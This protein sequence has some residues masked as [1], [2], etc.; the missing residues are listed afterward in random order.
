MPAGLRNSYPITT[1]SRGFSENSLGGAEGVLLKSGQLQD[2]AFLLLQ[3]IGQRTLCLGFALHRG[4]LPDHSFIADEETEMK[5]IF[6]G[7]F[8][9]RVSQ[10]GI[11]LHVKITRSDGNLAVAILHSVFQEFGHG[12]FLVV[13]NL[14]F[15]LAHSSTL[16]ASKLVIANP[17]IRFC[18]SF[19]RHI[20][21]N[22]SHKPI[23]ATRM[24]RKF[25]HPHFRLY[26][27]DR[28]INKLE[29]D[30]LFLP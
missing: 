7:R 18:F 11:T 27:E 19:A 12:A 10:V 13:D 14:F 30:C 6:L 21:P 3:L 25:I 5:V 16:I 17:Q 15:I 8:P 26:S 28:G 22:M 24:T 9:Q 29:I 23:C 1:K 2:F 4:I 20:L